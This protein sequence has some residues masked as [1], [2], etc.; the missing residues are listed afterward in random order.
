MP[1]SNVLSSPSLL[2]SPCPGAAVLRG[3]LV[4]GVDLDP[5]RHPSGT[6][7][8]L[9]GYDE[10]HGLE[11][12]GVWRRRGVRARLPLPGECRYK[13]RVEPARLRW[14][15]SRGRVLPDRGWNHGQG[16]CADLHQASGQGELP[17]SS[18][19]PAVQTVWNPDLQPVPEALSGS[20]PALHAVLRSVP[21]S[22]L[23]LPK[24][25][26]VKRGFELNLVARVHPIP[27][28]RRGS[29]G[30]S[31]LPSPGGRAPH[32]ERHERSFR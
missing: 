11:G 7:L 10:D 23:Q 27:P 16:G 12:G 31:A 18:V 19:F 22:V 3:V 20:C 32:P 6:A 13:H 21:R 1:S 30:G 14:W 24:H 29:P 9:R 28:D 2:S 26:E 25:R 4:G 17:L 5:G 8:L 15:S